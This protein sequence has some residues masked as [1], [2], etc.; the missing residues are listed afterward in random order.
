MASLA[1]TAVL[2]V[3][4]DADSLEILAYLVGQEG[5]TVRGAS[6]AREAL[7]LLLTW[8]PDVLLLDIS[9]PEIDGYELLSTIRGVARLR[10]VP[11]IAVTAHA[12]ETD[13]QRCIEAGFAEH[14]SK[15]YDGAA[16]LEL[17]ARL[18]S[19][20]PRSTVAS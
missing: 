1:G 6:S 16:L 17:V 8:T 5:G 19:E 2:V 18:A 20:K 15:P 11:A 13:K 3:D 10:D 4:D 14:I 12:Y 9:M 7:E